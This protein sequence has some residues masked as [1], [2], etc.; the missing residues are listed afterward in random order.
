MEDIGGEQALV[1]RLRAGDE[2]AFGDLVRR[3]H[4]AMVRFAQTFVPSHAIAEEVVQDAWLGVI[5]GIDR[6]EGVRPSTRGSSGSSPTSPAPAACAN[7]GRHRRR[8]SPR[9]WP[10]PLEGSLPP[11][12]QAAADRHLADCPHCREYLEQMRRSIGLAA[13]SRDDDVPAE[14]V[15][16]LSRAFADYRRGGGAG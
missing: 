9:S 5:R 16:A 1:E 7:A 2:A 13:R 14:V 8:C 6:F 12:L 4:A 3:H 11:A 15:D 10:T